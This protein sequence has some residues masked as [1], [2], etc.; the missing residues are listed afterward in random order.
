MSRSVHGHRESN[1]WAVTE[2]SPGSQWRQRPGTGRSMAGLGG[3]SH[4]GQRDCL[5]PA[6][7]LAP[8]GHPNIHLFISSVRKL[9]SS[10][11]VLG[12]TGC[13]LQLCVI[14]ERGGGHGQSPLHGLGPGLV[15]SHIRLRDNSSP[16]AALTGSYKA[17]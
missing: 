13:G 7:A 9:S 2:G 8:Q 10:P 17:N 12:N 14:S 3:A 16:P 5:W 11:D 6:G 4:P 1:G 15:P